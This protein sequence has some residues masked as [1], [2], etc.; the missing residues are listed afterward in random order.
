MKSTKLSYEVKGFNKLLFN[1]DYLSPSKI[2][3]RP[4]AVALFYSGTEALRKLKTSK[5]SKRLSAMVVVY[6][7]PLAM[8]F[9]LSAI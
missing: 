9:S 3:L 5:A 4:W 6:L 1:V 8:P 2:F 7:K